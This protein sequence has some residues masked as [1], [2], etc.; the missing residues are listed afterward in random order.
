MTADSRSGWASGPQGGIAL[1]GFRGAEGLGVARRRHLRLVATTDL[2]ILLLTILSSEYIWLGRD[3]DQIDADFGLGYTKFGVILAVVWWIALRLGGTRDRNTLGSTDEYQKIVHVT[4]MVFGILA[5]ATV[6]LELNLSR[7]YLGVAFPLGLIGLLLSRRQWRRWREAQYRQGRHVQRVLV[8]GSP[9]S[10]R[11]I[12]GWMTRH[13]EAGLRVTGVWRPAQSSEHDWLRVADQFIPVLGGGRS[14]TSAVTLAGAE[15]V[16]VSGTDELG[17]HGLRDLTWDLESAGVE[18]LVSPNLISVAGSRIGMREVA[19]M[20]FVHVKEPQYAEA[21]NWPKGAFDVFGALTILLLA[22]PLFLATA[23]AIKLT[24][25]GPVFYRQERI[26]RNGRPF[27][28]IKFRSMRV[29]ADEQLARLLKEQGTDGTP[30]FKVEDDP[31]ITRVGR[32]IRRYSIDELPQLI[33]VVRGEMSLVGPRPQREGEV[34]LYDRSAHRRL[35]VRPGMTGLWQVSGRSNLSW[36]EAIQLDM[37]YV[38]NWTLMGDLQIL[39][40][41]VK[42]VFAK[43]GAV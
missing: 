8:V 31:R 25:P 27:P 42:A 10:A 4:V 41:T 3:A 20:P 13:A 14:L 29:G 11:E 40:R 36:E 7:G 33:N 17:H 22:S 28:M 18:M 16:I 9:E 12:A 39:F 19:G 43:D 6:L 30:L 21:G 1:P 24:S 34:A 2:L 5:I 15:A 35:R 32:F 37:Y 23:L 38:E 26:G